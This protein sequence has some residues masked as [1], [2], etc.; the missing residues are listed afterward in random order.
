MLFRDIIA[1]NSANYIRPMNA[2]CG[3]D[4]DF[5]SETGVRGVLNYGAA[6]VRGSF[7]Q[8]LI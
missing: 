4:V 5:L 2:L 3:L 6:F 7:F 1:V 8:K